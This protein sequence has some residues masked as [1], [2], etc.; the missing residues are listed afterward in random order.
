ML[1]CILQS[2]AKKHFFNL[3]IFSKEKIFNLEI[4]FKPS[5]KTKK[6]LFR[7]MCIVMSISELS[8]RL[9]YIDMYRK[10]SINCSKKYIFN[11]ECDRPW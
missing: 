6:S 9:H 3:E 11:V 1:T 5:R 7:T 10:S 2:V 4:H 8:F